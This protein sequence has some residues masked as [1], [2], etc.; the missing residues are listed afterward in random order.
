MSRI[1]P[2]LLSV[3]GTLLKFVIPITFSFLIFFSIFSQS[4]LDIK[5]SQIV[6]LFMINFETQ[7][8][9]RRGEKSYNTHASTPVAYFFHDQGICLGWCNKTKIISKI[10]T[11]SRISDTFKW[12]KN[13]E[14][15]RKKNQNI[16]TFGYTLNSI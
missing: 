13:C 10:K 7:I 15:L 5:V 3:F 2:A 11:L 16:T 1:L 9:C 8:L 12:S 6:I 14:K 4:L